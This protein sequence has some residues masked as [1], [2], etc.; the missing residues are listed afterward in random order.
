MIKEALKFY[1]DFPKKG[2]IFVDIIP[3]LQ[4]KKIFAELIDEV[5][6]RA[7]AP[8]IVAPE[9]R[10]FLFTAPLM[11]SKAEVENIIPIRKSG[12]LPFNEGDLCDVEIMKEYG[13]DHLYYRLSDIAA[14]KVGDD[15]KIHISI[16]DD[17]LATGGTAEG[18]AKSILAGKVVKDGVEREVVI[19]EFIFLVEL[20]DLKGAE[21]LEKIAP[22][23]SIVH[24]Q[25]L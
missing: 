11:I 18:I 14:S 24:L 22:V 12:K 15:G 2:I 5:G 9:A 13:A 23:K 1:T 21:M 16:V 6:K 17:V 7:S 4:D 3:L 10:G 8:N 20:D 19:D 25:G